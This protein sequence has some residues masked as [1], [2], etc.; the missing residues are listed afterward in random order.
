[1][2]SRAFHNRPDPRYGPNF[3][4]SCA[5]SPID[6]E[7]E[8]SRRIR[9]LGEESTVSLIIAHSVQKEIDHPNTPAEVKREA[10]RWS[11]RLTRT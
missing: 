10:L 9:A 8:A 4:D 6:P 2:T 5:L 7:V 1:V 3:L 11:S